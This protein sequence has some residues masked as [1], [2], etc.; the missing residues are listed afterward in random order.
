MIKKYIILLIIVGITCVQAD[1]KKWFGELG[2]K[3]APSAISGVHNSFS[4]D[5]R[6]GVHND[7]EATHMFYGE[8][9]HT[10]LLQNYSRLYASVGLET[11]VS[12][13]PNNYTTLFTKASLLYPVLVYN[14]R[15]NIGPK[16]KLVVPVS[17]SYEDAEDGDFARKVEYDGGLGV[18]FGAE[19]VWNEDDLQFITGLEY[20]AG[21]DYSGSTVDSKGHAE[22]TIDLSGIYFN[23]GIRYRF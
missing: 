11:L 5:G 4:N 16:L 3:M 7:W 14:T 8:L 9:G 19:I 18:A 10:F 22:S 20:L 15:L 21:S 13:T 23:L 12:D 1:Q 17:S 2:W 6:N